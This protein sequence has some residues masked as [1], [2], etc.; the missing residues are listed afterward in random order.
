[1]PEFPI[2]YYEG[3]LVFTVNNDCYAVYRIPGREYKYKSKSGKIAQLHAAARMLHSA[4]TKHTKIIG[5][6]YLRSLREMQEDWKKEISGPLKDL[7]KMHT[8]GVTDYLMRMRGKGGDESS[9]TIPF[10]VVKLRRPGLQGSFRQKFK[11]QILSGLE[12]FNAFMGLQS[13]DIPVERFESFMR[14]EHDVNNRLMQFGLIRAGESDLEWLYKQPWFRGIGEPPLRSYKEKNAEGSEKWVTWHP[15]SARIIRRGD[16]VIS[17]DKAEMMGLSKGL[18]EKTIERHVKITHPNGKISFQ[19]FLIASFI[20]D[21]LFP[22]GNEWGY[23][24]NT[25]PFPVE[26]VFDCD[27]VTNDKALSKIDRRKKQVTDQQEHTSEAMELPI[28][29]INAGREGLVLEEEVKQSKED[30][31]QVNIEFC[32]YSD[33]LDRLKEK[34]AILEEYFKDFGIEVQVPISDQLKLFYDFFPGTQ[35]NSLAYVRPM[36]ARSLAGSMFTGTDIIGS[37]L[38]SYIARYGA[39]DKP[40]FLDPREA[41]QTNFSPSMSFTGTLGG[42]KS[43]LMDLIGYLNTISGGRTLIFDPKNDRSNWPKDMP[44][45]DGR[46]EVMCLSGTK[47]D[48]GKL[49]PFMMYDIVHKTGEEKEN[50]ISAAQQ[51]A[52]SQLSFALGCGTNSKLFLAISKACRYA[53]Y[54]DIPCM[55]R[56]IEYCKTEYKKDPRQAEKAEQY[57]HLLETIEA[58]LEFPQSSLLFGDGENAALNVTKPLTVM[59]IQNLTL[60]KKK[61]AGRDEMSIAEVLSAMLVGSMAAFALIFSRTDRGV[62]KWVEI[63]ESWFFRKIEQAW[64]MIREIIREGRAMNAGVGYVD[65]NTSGIDSEMRNNIGIRFAYRAG[66]IAEIKET[67]AYF[68][69]EPSPENINVIKNLGNGEC[70]MRD[71]HG[72]IQKI[73]VDAVYNSIIHALDTRPKRKDD[74]DPDD[75]NDEETA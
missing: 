56:V 47:T 2:K 43:F 15:G 62:F 68:D 42:G 67:L 9:D 5:K 33:N 66:D 24:L 40:V 22:D 19:S 73:K 12:G 34:V 39:L 59:Q 38:G 45:L 65:Q 36:S 51:L 48:E 1:M 49:D 27:H 37:K 14:V 29:I 16:V 70:L 18:M 74:P 26:Y 69:M 13:A 23:L 10:L 41:S 72:R 63:D 60:P 44:E 75:E 53:A 31:L 35:K 46:L 64:D 55:L 7:A 30:L 20:P 58:L 50:S 71:L 61:D 3:N 4:G 54:S 52:V 8:D 6:P 21:L 25:L 32:V 17:P 11:R 28:D 57:E